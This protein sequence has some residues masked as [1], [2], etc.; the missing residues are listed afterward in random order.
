MLA[1]ISGAG[2]GVEAATLIVINICQNY[3]ADVLW[4]ISTVATSHGAFPVK[5]DTPEYALDL[6]P[7]QMRIAG[8]SRKN[9]FLR[10]RADCAATIF[11]EIEHTERTERLVV[12]HLRLRAQQIG[13]ILREINCLVHIIRTN[14]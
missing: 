3:F 5:S 6:L 8:L 10:G 1:W 12:L 9:S 14:E 2:T 11:K 7:V 13:T 4:I